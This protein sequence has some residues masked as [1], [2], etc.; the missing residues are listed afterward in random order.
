V[1]PIRISLIEGLK[2]RAG[3]FSFFVRSPCMKSIKP[4]YCELIRLKSTILSVHLIVI[5]TSINAVT[6]ESLCVT[7][8]N[9]FR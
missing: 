9:R 2:D 1:V 8:T 5:V 4:F 6:D 3:F 7:S